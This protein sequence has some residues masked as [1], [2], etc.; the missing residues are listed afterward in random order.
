VTIRNNI[1]HDTHHGWGIQF[2]PGSLDNIRVANNTFAF[3]NES[4]SYTCIVLDATITNSSIKNNVF[5]NPQGGRTIEAAGF[6]GSITI[7]NNLTSGSAMHDQGSTPSGMTLTA[8]QLNTNA[9]L[10]NPPSDFHL[11]STSPAIDR[12]ETLSYVAIDHEGRAR[13]Q[14]CCFDIGAY[15][16]GG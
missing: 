1:F 7:G 11:R 5:Y 12:G 13:P 4:K 14:G 6:D 8:N 10:V 2:Y 9:Q 16:Y 15:E 3:C